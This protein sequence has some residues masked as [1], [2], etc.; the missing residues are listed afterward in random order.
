MFQTCRITGKSFEISEA[1]QLF[2]AK[3][4]VPFPTLCPSERFRR[5]MAYRNETSVYMRKSSK[6]GETIFS[7]YP[8]GSRFPVVEKEYWW[9]DE[10]DASV[11]A[12]EYDFSKSFFEQFQS[13]HDVVPHFP[14]S[15]IN[16]EESEWVNNA[17]ALKKCF[18]LFGANYCRDCM[19]GQ[20]VNY[21]EDC[22]DCSYVNRSVLCYDCVMCNTCYQV[23]S[24]IFCDECNESYYLRNCISCKNCFAC[25]NLY[26]KEYCIFNIQYS[27]EEYK[28]KFAQ[29][30]PKL[31]SYSQRKDL[32]KEVMRFW[33]QFPQPHIIAHQVEHVSGDYIFE[34]RN[35]IESYRMNNCENI[36]FGFS[37]A[38]AKDCMDYGT[39]GNKAELVYESSTCGNNVY[40]L[41]F[42]YEC[43]ENSTNLEYCQYCIGCDECFGCVGL[44]KKKYCVFNKQYT[45]EE[46]EHMKTKIIE[47]MKSLAE[48]GE[49]FPIKDSPVPYNRSEVYSY[50]PVTK[51]QAMIEGL[52]WY[53]VPD[54]KTPGAIPAG[55]LPDLLPA[56]NSRIIAES[57]Q[58][59]QS[60]AITIQ[61]IDMLRKLNAPLP[62]IAYDERLDERLMR[63]NSLQLFER[64]CQKTGKPIQ[65]SY[66]PNSPWTVWEK[67]VWEG[68]FR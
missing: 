60:F 44:K 47:H 28:M 4:N 9:S 61:E 12:R 51:E 27:A 50:Y 63:M 14:L 10:F 62:R 23:S 48:Y 37:L 31:Q 64:T 11:Y 29:L 46:Y 3:M 19:Y 36:K 41:K 33:L 22:M 42:C 43:Y 58:S 39:W 68:E 25:S 54:R 56:S 34:S 66:A 53:D 40:N 7:M 24:S 8:E 59:G 38:D 55:D 67:E 32:E 16:I 15:I 21:S 52:Q 26:R 2:Y 20:R 65:T 6:T 5:R 45:K 13:L 49:F 30:L 57:L 35:V 17:S 1:D 18:M